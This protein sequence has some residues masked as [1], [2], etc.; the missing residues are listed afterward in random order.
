MFL[1]KLRSWRETLPEVEQRLLD[2]LAAAALG[3]TSE[4]SIRELA[5]FDPRGDGPA[6][7]AARWLAT[8]WGM[9]YTARDW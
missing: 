3:E 1:E 8:P 7:C 4:P 5:S 9:A 6:G 2:S